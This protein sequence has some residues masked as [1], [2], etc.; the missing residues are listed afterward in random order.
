MTPTAKQLAPYIKAEIERIKINPK[1][2]GLSKRQIEQAIDRALEKY[3]A[4]K[5]ISN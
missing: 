1:H 4:A 5:T 2:P 3:Y